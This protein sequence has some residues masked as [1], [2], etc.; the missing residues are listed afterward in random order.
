MSYRL[1]LLGMLAA[2]ALA[3]PSVLEVKQPHCDGYYVVERHGYTHPEPIF[4]ASSITDTFKGCVDAHLVKRAGYD[5]NVEPSDDNWMDIGY[6]DHYPHDDLLSRIPEICNSVQCDESKSITD[7]VTG[8]L[9]MHVH[10]NYY[11]PEV[12]DNF[13]ELIKE[14]YRRSQHREAVVPESLG[15]FFTY[16]PRSMFASSGFGDYSGYFMAVYIS[17]TPAETPG[18]P[19]AINAINTVG[20][21]VPELAPVFGIA[22]AVCALLG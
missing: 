18:C 12:R 16:G 6:A 20:P 5:T 11:R 2:S 13:I 21:L 4:N 8:K 22:G 1:S 3:L 15:R 19:K 7:R 10:G 17:D 14:A 9:T